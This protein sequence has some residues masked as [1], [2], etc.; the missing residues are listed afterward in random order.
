MIVLWTPLAGIIDRF[1]ELARWLME[2][3]R[4]FAFLLAVPFIVALAGLVAE[5]VRQRRLRLPNR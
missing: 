2:L 3:D 4:P 5:F 1:D